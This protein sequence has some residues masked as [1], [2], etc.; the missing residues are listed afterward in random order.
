MIKDKFIIS[1]SRDKSREIYLRNSR[2]NRLR[3][4]DELR[5]STVTGDFFSLQ[6][7]SS[8]STKRGCFFKRGKRGRLGIGIGIRGEL[9][10][11]YRVKNSR[12]SVLFNGI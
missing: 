8:E 11:I 2:K 10:D 12:K 9:L 5:I 6:C 7:H 3:K 4:R 1:L